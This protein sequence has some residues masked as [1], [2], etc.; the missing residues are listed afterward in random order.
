MNPF[1]VSTY[2]SDEEDFHM[3]FLAHSV[4]RHGSEVTY[5]HFER[6]EPR[7]ERP[8]LFL[9]FGRV[10]RVGRQA[11]LVT[12]SLVARHQNQ[13]SNCQTVEGSAPL[14]SCIRAEVPVHDLQRLVAALAVADTFGRSCKFAFAES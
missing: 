9:N 12:V 2:S 14:C 1:V 13:D 11:C 4:S 3:L 8:F 7:V 6:R 10:G 5:A